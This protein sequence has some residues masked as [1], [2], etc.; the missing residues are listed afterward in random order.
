ML[1]E[2]D[3]QV[4]ILV[5]KAQIDLDDVAHKVTGA[6]VLIVAVLIDIIKE[7][8]KAAIDRGIL[9]TS[10]M[11]AG[12]GLVGILLAV[13]AVVEL[14]LTKLLGGFSLG[15]IGAI[16]IFLVVVIGSLFKVTLFSKENKN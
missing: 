2:G 3:L 8:K 4:R 10:G 1:A 14:D 7:K 9:Y 11:I 6:L 15:Q 12:E 16:L 13:F 5:D